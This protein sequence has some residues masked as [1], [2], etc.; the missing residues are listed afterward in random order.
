MTLRLGVLDQ[1]PV[2]GGHTP[3]QAVAET[4]ALARL[5]EDLGYGR[6]WLAEH[7]AIAALADPCPE[8]LLARIAAETTRMRVGTGGVLLPYYSPFKVAEVFRMLE[9]L[10]PGRIDLGIGRAPGGDLRTAQAVAYGAGVSAE[11]FPAQVR[12]LA[13]F[14]DGTLPA[15]HPFAGV[16]AQPAGATAPQIWLLGSSDYSGALA[17]ELGL[18]FAF[19]H[20]ISAHGAGA[21][22]RAYRDQ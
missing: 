7:H 19:A 6:Y 13:G 15:D 12:D 22:M 21:V 3:A 18:R 4:L 10:Y 17:S 8:I 11:H 2:V 20:F 1:S 5:A 16:K 9:A 14:L